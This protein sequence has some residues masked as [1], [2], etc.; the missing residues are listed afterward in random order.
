MAVISIHAAREGGDEREHYKEVAESI[1]IHAAREGGD[2]PSSPT[3]ERNLISIHA[4]R[5]GGDL[6]ATRG[7]RQKLYFNPRRP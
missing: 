4:A 3:P 2:L 6:S 1:S 5:E 7:E